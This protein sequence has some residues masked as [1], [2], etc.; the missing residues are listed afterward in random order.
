M[1]L[2]GRPTG[3]HH[4]AS[5]TAVSAGHRDLHPSPRFDR[6]KIFRH[7]RGVRPRVANQLALDNNE[8]HLVPTP[9]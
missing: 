3:I 9:R 7:H 1:A 8:I 6:C 2:A 4:G 5:L